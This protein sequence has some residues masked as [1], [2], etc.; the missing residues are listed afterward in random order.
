M[1][2]LSSFRRKR[3]RMDSGVWDLGNAQRMVAKFRR[4]E[5]RGRI[6]VQRGVLK[7]KRINVIESGSVETVVT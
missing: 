7:M 3:Q 1:V 2:L 4:D 6:S 5:A